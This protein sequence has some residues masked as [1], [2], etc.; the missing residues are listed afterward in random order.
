MKQVRS[1][2]LTALA[3]LAFAA[4]NKDEITDTGNP[5]EVISGKETYVSFSFQV[6]SNQ[7]QS[8]A[9]MVQEV[10][11]EDLVTA[12]RIL[13]FDKASGALLNNEKFTVTAGKTSSIKT[14][15]GERRIYIIAGA[16][17]KT[18]MNGK[19][20]GLKPT[21]KPTPTLK[22]FYA[23]MTDGKYD[24]TSEA[25]L[26][27][28]D[29][30]GELITN[31]SFVTSNVADKSAEYTLLPGIGKDQSATEGAGS[32]SSADATVNRFEFKVFRAVAKGSLVV[33]LGKQSA[34]KTEDGIFTLKPEATYGVRNVN[35][36]TLYVQQF[37]NDVLQAD[38]HDHDSEGG[39]LPHAAFYNAFDGPVDLTALATYKPYYFGGYPLTGNDA[40]KTTMTFGTDKPTRGTPVYFSENSN[41]KQVRGNTTYYGIAT[42]VASIEGD[43]IA[44]T[45]VPTG[46]GRYQST[47]AGVDYTPGDFWY[48]RHIPTKTQALLEGKLRRVFTSQAIAFEAMYIIA[49][50]GDVIFGTEGFK[51]GDAYTADDLMQAYNDNGASVG[52]N[53]LS[54]AD[55][56]LIKYYVAC[57]KN[58][59]S[60]YR[61]NL[62]EETTQTKTQRHLVRRNHDYQA[63]VTS[64][65][66][67]GDPEEG[68]L[69][70]D[71]ETPVDADIT[72]VTAIIS[73]QA[74]HPV[75]MSDDL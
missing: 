58:G 18:Q 64:F 16:D 69:D 70:K 56:D 6:G 11:N 1:I 22:D 75:G 62:Y 7:P 41:N 43:D 19:L 34:L 72:F 51:P 29:G 25:D 45:I 23:L 24:G 48:A 44:A 21:D 36:G 39:L 30:F 53:N 8:R 47:A 50:T 49:T 71:P 10:N 52:K 2:F 66:T 65:A 57:Y 59:V 17:G 35:R 37:L 12:G 26:T 4:C 60:Y 67:I 42:T 74:W 20:D 54:Q 40:Q 61:L 13:I 46:T 63:T 73:V 55:K 31:A 15:S 68:D 27:M 14:T 5:G 3:A 32:G 9:G 28:G 33:Q 38:K